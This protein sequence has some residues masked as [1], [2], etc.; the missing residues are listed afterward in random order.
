MSMKNKR[1]DR[2]RV[3][4]IVPAYNEEATI[5]SVVREIVKEVPGIAVCVIDDGSTDS[6]RI[7]A[8]ESGAIVISHPL[9]MGIG[10]AVQTGFMYAVRHEYDI[11]VQVDADGQHD[12]TFIPAMISLL[13]KGEADVV[14]GSRFLNKKGYKSSFLRR[15]GISFFAVMNQVLVGQRI[16]DSTSGFRAFSRPVIEL[17]ADTYPEDY[18]EPEVVIILKKAGFKMREVPVVMRER[19]GG[20]SSIRGFKPFHYMVKV[21]LAILMQALKGE[22]R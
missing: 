19:Q 21:I 7:R 4:A 15:L 9:N 20:R 3:L 17:L 18:P 5:A 11:A 8:Q 10:V 22:K 1:G 6:T 16:S 12:P 2:L 13:V 14:S